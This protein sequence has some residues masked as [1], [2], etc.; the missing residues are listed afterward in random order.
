MKTL[1]NLHEVIRELRET[2][3][4]GNV[5]ITQISPYIDVALTILPEDIASEVD[6][7][8]NKLEE[9]N[10][11]TNLGA[12]N[13]YLA[14]RIKKEFALDVSGF[15]A[16]FINYIFHTAE[17]LLY[18]NKVLSK[19]YLKFSSVRDRL[20]LHDMWVNF[21]E[22][23]EYNPPHKHAGLYSFVIWNRIPFKLEDELK[24]FPTTSDSGPNTNSAF[25]FLIPEDGSV[26]NLNIPVTKD[27]QNF[28]CM[29]PSD[30]MHC[31]HPFFTSDGYRVSLSGNIKIA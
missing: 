30:L 8:V 31:V 29:F 2:R 25:A 20:Y 19:Q 4:R 17:N 16:D 3:V 11:S 13:K 28:M 12:Y 1:D 10:F 23:Y 22:K 5:T 9:S 14:G 24:V 6:S 26:D 15:S 7:V 18:A 27:M 21:Q